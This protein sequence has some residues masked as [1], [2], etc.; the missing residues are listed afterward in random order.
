KMN[1]LKYKYNKKGIVIN[2]SKN[3]VNEILN[4]TNYEEFGA[5][6][7]DKIIKDKIENL[8]IENIINDKK[9]VTI[10]TIEWSLA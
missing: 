9:K 6:K 2:F 7:I 1:K 5:R 8:I 10:K 3:I 4:L